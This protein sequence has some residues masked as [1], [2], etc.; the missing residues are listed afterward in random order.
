MGSVR[1]RQ[2]AA[3]GMLPIT[4]LARKLNALK[5]L[6]G[7]SLGVELRTYRRSAPPPVRHGLQ[8][9]NRR[10]RKSNL[11]TVVLTISPFRRQVLAATNDSLTRVGE[12]H[13]SIAHSTTRRSFDSRSKFGIWRFT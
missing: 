4:F 11:E 13:E 5:N 7:V 3:F 12:S 10:A 6:D 1:P 8:D 2:A 9:A